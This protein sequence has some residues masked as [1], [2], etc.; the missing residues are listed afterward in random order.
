MIEVLR[1]SDGK[2]LCVCE[3][4]R[5]CDDGSFDDNGRIIYVREIESSAGFNG[6]IKWALKEFK[7]KNFDVKYVLWKRGYKYPDRKYVMKKTEDIMRRV[8]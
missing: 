3:W 2:I 6:A 8:G 7:K 5:V 4:D 1:D